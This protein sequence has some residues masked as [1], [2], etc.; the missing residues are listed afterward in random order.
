MGRSLR[1]AIAGDVMLGRLVNEVVR[2]KGIEY[3]W[4]DMLPLLRQADLFLV[5]LECAI[6]TSTAPWH[7]GEYK[8]F[9]FRADPQAAH[10]LKA[11]G[12][13]FAS[14][15]NNHI[16]DFGAQGLMDTLQ[17][18][19]AAGIAHAGAGAD[20]AQA[21]SPARL[22]ADG[23]R[24]SVVA[25]ADYPLAWA[26]TPDSPGI[27]YTPVS[28]Q[29]EDFQAV[30][31]ALSE[32]RQDA[33]LVIFSIHW[34]PNMRV[35]PTEA[36]QEFAR[37]VGSSGADIFWGHSAHLVQ[38]IELY[39]EKLILYDTGDLVDDY[40]VDRDLRNDLSALFVVTVGPTG[41]VERLELVPVQIG[42][43]QVNMAQ[44][45]ARRWMLDRLAQLSAEMG[46]RL[47]PSRSGLTLAMADQQPGRA[48]NT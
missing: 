21:R 19:D 24:V 23:L 33:D 42:E 5:N 13:K 27:N 1:L 7:N 12:V 22:T 18:L 6:T 10:T 15:A 45:A 37:K 9:Y 29:P 40:A 14:L 44:G 25:F 31:D 30:Q 35:R 38:G 28:V 43:M 34:G 4:G 47:M 16:C 39:G 46:T 26:A 11:A 8:L 32:A 17:A 20:L 2:K 48:A 3:P 36:F 41:A